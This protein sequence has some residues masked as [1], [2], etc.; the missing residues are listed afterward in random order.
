M[1]CVKHRTLEVKIFN[2][3]LHISNC[4][5]WWELKLSPLSFW[6]EYESTR[7]LAFLS[8]LDSILKIYYFF[9]PLSTA[10][11]VSQTPG[12]ARWFLIDF[13]SKAFDTRMEYLY[14]FLYK[15]ITKFLSEN[16]K[17]A[18]IFPPPWSRYWSNTE[19]KLRPK[20]WKSP[21]YFQRP[22]TLYCKKG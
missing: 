15:G 3:H 8:Y 7:F 12:L 17:F 22:A 20:S 19:P 5:T 4:T 1:F 14:F 13:K 21:K 18:K 6:K 11:R 16:R 10:F 9:G 2:L